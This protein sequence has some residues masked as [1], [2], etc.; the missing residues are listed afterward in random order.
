MKKVVSHERMKRN[1]CF[2]C[3]QANPEGLRL[4]VE[5]DEAGKR[6]FVKFR[7]T[8]R[9][10][11]PPGH[12]HGGIIATILDEIMGKINKLRQVTAMTRQ[13]TID[14]LKPVPLGQ[15]LIAEGREQSVHGRLHIRV[16]EIRNQQGEVLALSRGTFVVID[17]DQVLGKKNW[18]KLAQ[19]KTSPAGKNLA[20]NKKSRAGSAV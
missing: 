8:R 16:G 9:Y 5:W 19:R 10:T 18:S 14:Y 3:G 1:Y 15:T 12:V 4:N 2:G 7:L 13:M 20:G 11:G 17:P 6:A